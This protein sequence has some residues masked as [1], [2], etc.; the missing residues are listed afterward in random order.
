ME[1]KGF[2]DKDAVDDRDNGNC[3]N[4]QC[5][6]TRRDATPTVVIGAGS[7]ELL[8]PEYNILVLGVRQAWL[9]G[10]KLFSGDAG[11]FHSH[12]CMTE[13]RVRKYALPERVSL[14]NGGE[15]EAHGRR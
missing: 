7:L 8:V 5:D 6:A 2:E 11:H 9:Y 3:S 4:E 12:R 14:R 10:T 1:S 13:S 15:N